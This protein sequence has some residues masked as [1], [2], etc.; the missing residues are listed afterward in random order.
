M[1]SSPPSAPETQM[2]RNW[3]CIIRFLILHYSCAKKFKSLYLGTT[4]AATVPPIPTPE[5]ACAVSS[6]VQTVVTMAASIW[7]RQAQHA[8][9]HGDAC[10][11]THA[12][13]PHCHKF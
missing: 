11:C 8:P 4:T 3:N 1:D 7:Y 5:H 6:Y 2:V 10:N 9:T 12:Q 13:S